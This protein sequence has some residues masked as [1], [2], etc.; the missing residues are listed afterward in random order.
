MI[1]D[2]IYHLKRPYHF[3]KTGLLEGIPAELKYRFP[4]K[5]LKIIAITGTDGKTTSSTLLYHVLKSAGKRVGLISTVAA[6]LGDEELDT[7][8]HVTA[9]QPSQVLKL[10]RRMVDEGYEYLI[11]ESTSHGIYQFR[12]WGVKPMIAGV[13]NITREHLDYHVTYENYLDAKALLLRRSQV[14]VIN[15]DDGSYLKI[16]K[17]LKGSR[18][19]IQSDSLPSKLQKAVKD[20]FPERYNQSNS[21][22]VIAISRLLG[23]GD[24]DIAEAIQR[25][26]NIKGRMQDMP[27]NLGLRIVVDFAHTPQALEEALKTLRVQ[28]GGSKK[29]LIAVFGCAG[30]RDRQKRPAMTKVASELADLAVLT[31]EDPRTE[32][33]WSII[34]QMKE[35][36]TIGHNKVYSIPDRG[37]AIEFAINQLAAKGDTVGIF[38]KGHE[39]SMCYGTTEH[40]WSDQ[41]AVEKLV[42]TGK[43]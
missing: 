19:S 1:A 14:S 41:V 39:L 31:A 24:Q 20:R 26:P 11:L 5:K 7:G 40:P 27:N 2:L 37:R 18:T 6:Y 38:G 9:P 33:V 25:F 21:R 29:K 34:R 42:T 43:L 3:V 23:I 13:T 22:L 4:Q 36:L 10:M 8:F 35:G 30:L 16:R 12:T 28:Q 17:A 32:D 15:E